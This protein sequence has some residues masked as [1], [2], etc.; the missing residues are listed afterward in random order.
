MKKAGWL[1]CTGVL[2][3]SATDTIQIPEPARTGKLAYVRQ[4]GELPANFDGVERS[5]VPRGEIEQFEWNDS[6]VYPGTTRSV[7]IYTPAQ[8]RSDTP[9]AVMVWQDGES[10]LRDSGKLRVRQTMDNLIADGL[11]PVTVGI[12]INP[13]QRPPLA[14]EGRAPPNPNLPLNRRIEYDTPDATYASFLAEEII[15]AVRR[16]R[17][18]STDR[19]D[20]AIVGKSSGGMAAFTT[21]WSRPDI[22]SKVVVSN[23]SF[24]NLLGG[25]VVPT[26]IAESPVKPL[27]ISLTSGPFDLANEFGIWWDANRAV[28]AALEHRGYDLQT[29]WGDGIHNPDFGAFTL[30]EVLRWIWRDHSQVLAEPPPVR[31]R[32]RP[33]LVQIPAPERPPEYSNKPAA[34]TRTPDYYPAHADSQRMPNVPHGKVEALVWD[35]SEI[36]PGTTRPVWIYVPAQYDPAHPAAVM[37]FQDGGT[38]VG[39]GSRYQVPT[40]FDNLIASGEMPVTIGVFVEP[41]DYPSERRAF[42][43]PIGPRSRQPANRRDEY[44]NIDGRYARYLLEE[45]LPLVETRY[46][47]S[48]D[49]ADRALVGNSSGGA[50]AFNAAWH[51]SDQFGKVVS[52][53][54]SF[55]AIRGAHHYP[56][57]VRDSDRKPLRVFLQSGVNDQISVFGNW[58]EANLAMAAALEAKCYDLKTVWGD[59]AHTPHHSAAIFPETL[60]WLWRDHPQ[61]VDRLR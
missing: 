33:V 5:G 22:F 29:I 32:E 37:V 13:G 26:W 47:L 51:R 57:I 11:M 4:P 6:E 27:R 42:P 31:R 41:G 56:Q 12:F 8:Y 10:Y 24:V 28:A 35:R 43:P 49:P 60:R 52:H 61:V 54:G 25:D 7:W 59:G 21:A 40:V 44:D 58:W 38:W 48:S 55:T 9:A 53:I 2:T 30:G 50:A 15:P 17:N 3:V 23:G 14:D 45:I 20:W 46:R 34:Y 1:L 16:R 18:L 36:Y 19:R 39:A